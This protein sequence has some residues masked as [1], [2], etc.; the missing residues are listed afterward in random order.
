MLVQI[1][2][3]CMVE[4]KK[5]KISTAAYTWQGE[6]NSAGRRTTFFRDDCANALTHERANLILELLE[7]QHTGCE[8]CLGHL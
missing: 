6:V 8:R 1:K 7:K 4:S 2:T 5:C 3:T